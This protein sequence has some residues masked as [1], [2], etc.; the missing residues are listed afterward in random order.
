MQI[1]IFGPKFAAELLDPAVQRFPALRVDIFKC[2]AHPEAILG[3]DDRAASLKL[4]LALMHLDVH[5]RT[6]REGHHGIDEA[7]SVA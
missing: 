1:L 3:V 7:S 5:L 4:V 6:Y 2:H